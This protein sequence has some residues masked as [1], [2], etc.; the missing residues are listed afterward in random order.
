MTRTGPYCAGGATPTLPHL[1]PVEIEES[2]RHRN[3]RSAK[4]RMV[5]YVIVEL[6]V[7]YSIAERNIV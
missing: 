3:V 5:V 1:G 2:E 4:F 7:E 6:G